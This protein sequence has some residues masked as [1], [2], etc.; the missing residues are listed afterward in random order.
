MLQWMPLYTLGSKGSRELKTFLKIPLISSRIDQK[1]GFKERIHRF[2]KEKL[3]Q[4]SWA[5]DAVVGADLRRREC[6]FHWWCH[7]SRI[8]S[9]LALIPLQSE[10]RWHRDRAMNVHWSWCWCSNDRCPIQWEGLIAWFCAEGAA[11]AVDRGH[12]RTTIRSRSCHNWTKI[13]SRSDHDRVAIGSCF[14]RPM[15]IATW[16]R[17]DV[18]E[19]ST[20]RQGE[21]KIG[22]IR[23][24]SYGRNVPTQCLPLRRIATVHAVSPIAKYRDRPIKLHLMKIWRAKELH[25][26]P[27]WWRWRSSFILA[28]WSRS[29]VVYES[30]KI[31]APREATWRSVITPIAST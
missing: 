27:V 24:R 2:L 14:R 8:C 6:G 10:P 16:W 20:R 31:S 17:S 28:V 4:R 5:I 18:P 29:C 26:S 19:K 21:M 25:E 12:D 7:G 23:W 1:L 9:E 15:K 13:A 22:A 3:A 11:I 30:M